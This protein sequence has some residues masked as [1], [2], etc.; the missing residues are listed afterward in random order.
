[1]PLLLRHGL[2]LVLTKDAV[3]PA[4]SDL[5]PWSSGRASAPN[6]L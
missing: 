6:P 1:M 4:G 5:D 3:S 2:S